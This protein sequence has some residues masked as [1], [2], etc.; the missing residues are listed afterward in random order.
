MRMI[1]MVQVM[2]LADVFKGDLRLRSSNLATQH[3]VILRFREMSLEK[4]EHLIS[5][6]GHSRGLADIEK[7]L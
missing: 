3:F 1:C 2:L 4:E 7:G 6:V 5:L